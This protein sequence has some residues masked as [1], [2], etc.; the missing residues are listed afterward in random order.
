MKKISIML[1]MLLGVSVAFA[2]TTPVVKTTRVS[3]NEIPAIVL[4]SFTADFATYGGLDTKGSW[5]LR[6]EEDLKGRQTVM[7]PISYTFIAKDKEAG[8]M[9]VTYTPEGKVEHA[10]GIEVSPTVGSE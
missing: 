1:S 2:Q 9:E 4:K 6:Y 10:S 8:K 3:Q 7:R 5:R